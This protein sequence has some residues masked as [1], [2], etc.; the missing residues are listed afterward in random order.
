MAS[1]ADE[2]TRTFEVELD[3]ANPDGRLA[4]GVSA[5]IRIDV[6]R[7]P[8]HRVSPSVL[9]LSDTGEL[10]VKTVGRD[11]LVAFMPVEIA[12]AEGGDVWL[13][14][15]PSEVR[16]ISVGQGFVRDGTEVQPVPEQ[17]DDGRNGAGPVVSEAVR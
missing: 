15:L 16:V 10:G 1:Q 17:G 5:E 12:R 8:A 4:A 3:L 7:V 13:T 9:V 6:E 11:D 14:G 2:Q